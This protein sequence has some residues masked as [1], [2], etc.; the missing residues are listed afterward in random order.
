MTRTPEV[1]AAL[2]IAYEKDYGDLTSQAVMT[3]FHEDEQVNNY[4]DLGEAY[5]T[6]LE[7][8]TLVDVSYALIDNSKDYSIRAF[9]KNVTDERYRVSSQPVAALWVFSQYGPPRTA[10]VEMTFDF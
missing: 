10:G 8:K 3:I 1:Q 9:V 6:I 2:Q 4:S 5:D 7:S